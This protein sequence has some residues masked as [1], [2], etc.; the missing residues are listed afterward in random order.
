[1]IADAVLLFQGGVFAGR[2]RL[3]RRGV[4]TRITAASVGGRVAVVVAAVVVVAMV[5]GV[6]IVVVVVVVGQ[7]QG[8]AGRVVHGQTG[9]TVE[10]PG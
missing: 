10:G 6:V 8:T 3:G 9:Y 5:V 2:R 7:E 4:Q 1:M